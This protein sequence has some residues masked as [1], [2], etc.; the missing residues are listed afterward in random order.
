VQHD[1]RGYAWHRRRPSAG[2]GPDN[3]RA[4]DASARSGGRAAPPACDGATGPR[5]DHPRPLAQV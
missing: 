4:V 3:K 5:L 2:A 1:I